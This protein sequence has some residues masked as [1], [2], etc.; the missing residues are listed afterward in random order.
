M[1]RS[2]LRFSGSIGEVFMLFSRFSDAK[3]SERET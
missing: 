1:T 3:R 2:R